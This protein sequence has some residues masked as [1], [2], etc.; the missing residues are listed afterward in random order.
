[1]SSVVVVISALRA[2]V[3]CLRAYADSKTLGPVVRSVVSL[4]NSLMV[5]MSTVLVSTIHVSN[6]L[7]FLLKNVSS[8]CY[9]VGHEN[10]L[11]LIRSA[12]ARLR[13][14]NIFFQRNKKII[15]MYY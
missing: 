3:C 13:T 2:I 5:K 6:S 7:I 1:M 8:F 10:L 15:N 9:D 14:H 11:V 12:L 4:T